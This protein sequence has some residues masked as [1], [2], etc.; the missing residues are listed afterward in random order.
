VTLA[1]EEA[2]LKVSDQRFLRLLPL[3]MPTALQTKL[4]SKLMS[5]SSKMALFSVI[6]PKLS[7]KRMKQRQRRRSSTTKSTPFTIWRILKA[8]IRMTAALS[9][10]RKSH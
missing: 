7:L 1:A 3:R 8:M 9:T 6:N 4:R 2:S 5:K 10:L